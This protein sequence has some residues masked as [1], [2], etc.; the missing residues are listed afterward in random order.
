MLFDPPRLL[1]YNYDDERIMIKINEPKDIRK[2]IS[3]RISEACELKHLPF[4][5]DGGTIVQL[6]NVWLRS[7]ETENFGGHSGSNMTPKESN[8]KSMIETKNVAERH[9][10][11]FIP[12][13]KGKKVIVRL[14][15]GGQPITGTIE[16]YNPQ[17]ILIQDC[18]RAAPGL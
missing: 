4:E 5:K 16:G 13:L 7:S 6:L 15:S 1:L 14:S 18:I 10:P 2:L 3:Q 8:Q 9:G 17:E 12:K 11:R